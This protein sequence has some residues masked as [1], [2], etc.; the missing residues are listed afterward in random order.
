VPEETRFATKIG[1]AQRMLERAFE[2]GV[3]ARWVV[4]DAFSGRSH[5]LRRWLEAQGRAYALMV[6]ETNAVRYQGRRQLAGPLG[7]DLATTCERL[8]GQTGGGI[9]G[10]RRSGYGQA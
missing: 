8:V 10:R 9:G 6:P 2:A 5:E 4:A 7:A 1:L 3:P